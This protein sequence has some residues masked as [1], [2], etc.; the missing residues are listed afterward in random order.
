MGQA[1]IGVD[2]VAGAGA[3][4]GVR[5]AMGPGVDGDAHAGDVGD[6]PAG[7]LVAADAVTQRLERV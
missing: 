5:G 6:A 7:L 4:A 1:Q 3:L 2:A